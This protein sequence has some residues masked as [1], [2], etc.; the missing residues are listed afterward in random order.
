V[1]LGWKTWCSLEQKYEIA[2][3]ARCL[4]EAGAAGFS[5]GAPEP[6]ETLAQVILGALTTGARVIATAVDAGAARKNVEKTIERLLA[7]LRSTAAA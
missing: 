7:G 2:A 6:V 5:K 3:F 1:V 4:K